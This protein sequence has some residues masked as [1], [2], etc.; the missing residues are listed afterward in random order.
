MDFES[1]RPRQVMIQNGEGSRSLLNTN[2][3][4]NS[5]VTVGT[6]ILTN[7]EITNQVSRKLIEFKKVLYTQILDSINLAISEKVLPAIQN[8]IGSQTTRV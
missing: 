2:G 5:E 6:A 1:D 7:S 3:R 4:Q 8:T